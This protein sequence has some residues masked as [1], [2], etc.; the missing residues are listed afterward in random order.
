VGT[1]VGTLNVYCDRP[2]DWDDTHISAL[3]AYNALLE[4]RLAGALVERAHGEIVDQLQFA[5]D[6][7]VVIERAVGLLMGRDGLDN[8]TAFQELRRSARSSRRR[9]L[10]VAEEVLAAHSLDGDGS[11]A[12]PGTYSSSG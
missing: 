7:R 4:A 1:P 5:L 3:E 2:R 8:V 10:T 6:S 12:G 11:P 9:V